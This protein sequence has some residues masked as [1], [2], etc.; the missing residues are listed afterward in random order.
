MNNASN[1]IR[2][3]LLSNGV[4]IEELHHESVGDPVEYSHK[5][6][7]RLEQQAKAILLRCKKKGGEKSFLVVSVPA[8]KKVDFDAIAKQL[9]ESTKSIRVAEKEQLF[10]LTNCNPGEL[11]PLGKLW[12]IQLFFDKDLFK[13]TRIYF[14][15]GSLE[16]SIIANPHD[17]AMIECA[18][19]I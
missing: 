6:G 17:I 15:A 1:K 14:N 7:T 9:G 8:N 19:L 18:I 13:E 5:I 4:C 16:Y 2:E 10:E 3:Y 11:P 12:N